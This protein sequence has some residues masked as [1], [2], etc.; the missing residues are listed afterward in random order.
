MHEEIA[1]R[2]EAV[3]GV[4]SVGVSSAITMDG[5]SNNDPIWVE[6]FPE[7]DAKIPALR[8]MKYIGARYF[9]TM[10]NPV[11]AGRDI[12]WADVA[13]RRAGG[14]PQREPRARILGRAGQG[15]RQAHAAHLEDRAG[16]RSSASSATSG[17][18][19]PPS[20]RH[21]RSTGR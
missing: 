13:Q 2:I 3:G 21:R 9:E 1:H 8:R 7:A 20:R 16:S 6:D 19:A 17:R 12:T 11:I 18:M 15:D 4:E 10:G 14:A 5:N